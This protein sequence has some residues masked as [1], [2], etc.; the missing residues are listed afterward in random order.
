[1]KRLTAPDVVAEQRL[2]AY[3]TVTGYFFPDRFPARFEYAGRREARG[4][5]YDVVTVTPEDAPSIDLWLD[6]ESHRLQRLTGQNGDLS[7]ESEIRRYDAV[8]GVSVPA[9]M[10]Q[11]VG[12][13]TIRHKVLTLEFTDVADARF[14]P[15]ESE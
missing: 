7:Y 8:D 14:A 2:A 11:T 10:V 15:P 12:G 3:V 1:M 4:I 5:A 9:E 13:Q 6:T